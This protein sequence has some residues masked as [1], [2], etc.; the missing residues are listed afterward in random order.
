MTLSKVDVAVP[1]KGCRACNSRRMYKIISLGNQHVSD[2][3]TSSGD[4]PRAP[5]NLVRCARCSLVQLGHTFPRESLYRQY[6]YRSGISP[7]MR[8]ALE[9]IVSKACDIVNPSSGDIVI[10]IGCNDGTL[11]RSYQKAGLQLVGF[12]PAKN[13]VQEARKVSKDIF[14]DFFNYKIFAAQFDGSKAKIVTSIAMFY[15]LDDPNSFITDIVKC[16]DRTGIWVI[17]QNYL[18]AMLRNNGFDNI[19]HEHLTYYSLNTLRELLN[20]SGLEIFHVETNDVNGGSF[21]TYVCHREQFPTRKSVE[22]LEA[23]E[24]ELFSRRPSVYS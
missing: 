24:R 2:F 3:V 13:L 6:W 1:L 14:N 18:P 12:E 7:T 23:E 22:M 16:L 9:D 5:L 19:G 11:L 4:S 8:A 10:D 21:R 15:D 20:K 17:Q